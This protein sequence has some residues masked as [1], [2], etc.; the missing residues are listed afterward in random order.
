LRLGVIG[1]SGH[2]ALDIRT[3]PQLRLR[4]AT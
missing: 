3:V 4:V 1:S 2:K